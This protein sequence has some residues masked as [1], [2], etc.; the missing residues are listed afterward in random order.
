MK[1][2]ILGMAIVA[3]VSGLVIG[4]LAMSFVKPVAMVGILTG[5]VIA[6]AGRLTKW[7]V[8]GRV[9]NAV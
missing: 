7:A 3:F 5:L 8:M 2:V 4:I 6:N 1:R 9:D